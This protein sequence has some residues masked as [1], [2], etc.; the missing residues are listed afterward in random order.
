MARPGAFPW[1]LFEALSNAR[2]VTGDEG[3]VR[4]LLRDYLAPHADRMEVDAMGSLLV[5]KRGRRTGARV[6]LGAHM[7]EVGFMVVRIEKSGALRL[8]KVG[9]LDDRLLAGKRVRV[10]PQALP[11]VLGAKPPHL[12]QEEEASRTVKLEDMYADIGAADEAEARAHVRVGDTVTFDA[13]FEPWGAAL[14]RGKAFDDR[15]G[16]ALLAALVAGPSPADFVAAFTTQE[17][18]G[19]RGARVAAQ[20]FEPE[21]AVALEGTGAVDVPGKRLAAL[22]AFPCLGRGPVLTRR[23]STTISDP[24][25]FELFERAAAA[26]GVRWQPKRP[27]IGGTDAGEYHRAGPGARAISVS[28]PCRYIHAPAALAARADIEATL[29]LVRAALPKL[30][31]LQRPGGTPRENS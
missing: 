14:V 12:G 16:C 13:A 19:L 20:R 18:I 7:D 26:A 4:R 30:A 2:G 21:V 24:R 5:E 15:V 6:L 3:P 9:G 8:Q 31:A 1:E 23:D 29:E 28:V 27:G 10:G 17:E 22:G 11:G 25:L